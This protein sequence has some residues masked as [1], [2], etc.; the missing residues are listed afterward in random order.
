[1]E[2]IALI[3]YRGSGK[4]TVGPLVAAR[5]G[6]RFV[7]ADVVLEVKAGK[8]IA[9]IFAEDGEI[10]FRDLEAN[11]L[12]NLLGEDDIVLATGGGAILRDSNRRLL[13]ETSFVVWLDA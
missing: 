10:Q 2:R 11:N 7:D 6:W 8:S 5:L 12:V 4:S 1:M 3:G 9:R 13:K